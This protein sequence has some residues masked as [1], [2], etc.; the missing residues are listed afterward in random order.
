MRF[1]VR[2]RVDAWY[3]NDGV[4]KLSDL[5]IYLHFQKTLS[6]THL[7]LVLGLPSDIFKWE[8]AETNTAQ[9]ML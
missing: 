7:K 3:A 6:H 4:N 2:I 8:N 9:T 5:H 1:H